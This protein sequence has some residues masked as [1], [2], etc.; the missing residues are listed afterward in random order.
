MKSERA[1]SIGIRFSQGFGG[2]IRIDEK[3]TVHGALRD[4]GT[5]FQAF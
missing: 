5:G 4:G 2:D 1:E 3:S